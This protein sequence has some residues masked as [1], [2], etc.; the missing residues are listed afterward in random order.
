MRT[1]NL[2][3]P[4]ACACVSLEA[5]WQWE[6]QEKLDPI[7]RRVWTSVSDGH[8]RILAGEWEDAFDNHTDFHP[9][10]IKSGV[11]GLE[12]QNC[13][14]L[15]KTLCCLE[16]AFSNHQQTTGRDS[17]TNA[18]NTSSHFLH[19][20]FWFLGSPNRWVPSRLDLSILVQSTYLG[21]PQNHCWYLLSI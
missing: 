20:S 12:W 6:F 8:H 18:K 14:R 21:T 17:F 5:W 11:R 7:Q 9:I 19:E 2:F 1:D 16:C 4:F 15:E 10:C 13:V 3:S